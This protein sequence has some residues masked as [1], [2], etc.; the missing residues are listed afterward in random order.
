VSWDEV[1]GALETG[2]AARLS[3][4]MTDVVAR[5]REHGDLFAPVLALR[6]ELRW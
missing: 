5:I 2:D 6:Q 4:E 3:F 1:Q